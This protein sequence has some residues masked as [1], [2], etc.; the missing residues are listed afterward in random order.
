M[1]GRCLAFYMDY[2]AYNEIYVAYRGVVTG[3]SGGSNALGNHS[4]IEVFR[5][6][7]SACGLRHLAEV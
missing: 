5:L 6:F 3:G 7:E 4:I 2:R 1:R